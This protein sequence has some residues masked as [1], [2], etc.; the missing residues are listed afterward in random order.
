MLAHDLNYAE[1]TTG[2][3]RPGTRMAQVAT[4][5]LLASWALAV[6]LFCLAN[7]NRL[8]QHFLCCRHPEVAWMAFV[9]APAVMAGS[10]LFALIQIA[11]THGTLTA[12][13][14]SVGC[15]LFGMLSAIVGL[16]LMF[17]LKA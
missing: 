6:T 12:W 9:I 13:L 7:T 10:G 11:R 5:G 17:A 14:M 4:V 1:P 3:R 15:I 16:L 8:P 2:V